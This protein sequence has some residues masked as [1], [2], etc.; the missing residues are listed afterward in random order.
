[1]VYD[2]NNGGQFGKYFVQD[3]KEPPNMVA[4]EF[5]E[6]YNAFAKRVLWMDSN[7]CEGAFR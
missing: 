3:L 2:N 4:P 6:I 1:M 5:R 7:V